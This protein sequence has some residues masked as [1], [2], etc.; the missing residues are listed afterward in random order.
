MMWIYFKGELPGAVPRFVGLES[1]FDHA[2]HIRFCGRMT[3][4]VAEEWQECLPH[5]AGI[6]RT[7]RN[8]DNSGNKSENWAHAK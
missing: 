8:W 1:E 4:D 7:H 3:L 2:E 6:R 5:V